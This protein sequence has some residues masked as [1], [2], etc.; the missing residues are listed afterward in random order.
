MNSLDLDDPRAPYLQIAAALRAAILTR[1]IQPGEKL[2]S[3][4]ELAKRYGVV[5]ATVQTALRMLKDEGLIVSRQG[6]GMYA[7]ERTAKPVGL[8]PHLEKAFETDDVRIDFVGYTSETLHGAIVEPLDKIRSGRLTPQSIRIRMLLSDMTKP[9]GLPVAT[10]GDDVESERS[11]ARM[12]GIGARNLGAITDSILELGDLGLVPNVDVEA[13]V[14]T[15]AP[16]FK[17]Y[18]INDSEAFFGFYPV[19]EHDVRAN[20]D[21][22]RIYDPMGKD[23]ILFHHADDGD[24]ESIDARFVAQVSTWFESVWNSVA[25]VVPR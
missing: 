21:L 17:A 14:F 12:A 1:K 16:V 13:R 11:R 20:G 8:R 7:R 22:I 24:P 25:T 6:S 3:Q 9:L 5:R 4:T 10:S 23:A 15:S 19:V 18:V 2:P